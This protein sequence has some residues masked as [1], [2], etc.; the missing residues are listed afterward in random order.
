[1]HPIIQADVKI[2]FILFL[3]LMQMQHIYF[4][5]FNKRVHMFKKAS[6]V[7]HF[8]YVMIYLKFDFFSL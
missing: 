7:S 3:L 8:L 1:M 5:F 2:L 4:F 6:S